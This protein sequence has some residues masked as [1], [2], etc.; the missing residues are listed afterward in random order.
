VQNWGGGVFSNR[1]L[2]MSL[3]PDMDICM[4]MVFEY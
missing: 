1:Q 4:I 3:H 2:E